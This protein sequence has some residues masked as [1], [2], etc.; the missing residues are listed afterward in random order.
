[1]S[2]ELLEISLYAMAGHISPL[3][4]RLQALING[5]MVQT[6]FDGGITHDFIQDRVAKFLDLL[7]FSSFHF[8]V[9]VGNG[10]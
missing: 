4:L 6:L 8:R 10:Q 9:L 3:T 5:F 1:M 7:I 2:E